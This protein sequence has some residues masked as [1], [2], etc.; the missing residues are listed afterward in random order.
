M[1]I[2]LILGIAAGYAAPFAEDTIRRVIAGT[3]LA[4][5]ALD[6]PEMRQLSFAVCLLGAALLA[7]LAGEG[8][9]IALALGAVL[10]VFTPRLVARYRARRR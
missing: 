6:A 7:A 4:D 3:T 10:G 9:S 1:L 2:N 8:G 5:P